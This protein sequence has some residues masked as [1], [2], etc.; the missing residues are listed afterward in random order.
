MYKIKQSL[1]WNAFIHPVLQ[2]GALFVGYRSPNRMTDKA[3]LKVLIAGG[4]GY[5]NVG[6][7]AQ[8]AA[9]L[10]LW[11]KFAPECRV[12][13]LTPDPVYTQ[14]THDK[15][16]VEFAT[17]VSLF[18][19]HGS[20]YFGSEKKFKRLYFLVAAVC[21]FNACLVRASLPT[22]G[23]TT[24]QARLLD[25]LNDSDVL[26]L[27]GGGYLTGMTLTRLWDNMLLIR[28]AHALGVPTILSGQTIGV[29]K[30][31]IS[32][33]LA[34]W[35]LK[36]AELIY[37]RD[38]VDSPAALAELGIS[39]ERFKCTFDDALFIGAAPAAAIDE[40]L[41][42][43]GIEPEK[44]YVAVNVH[45]WGL[46]SSDSRVIM[47]GMA[48]ILDRVQTSLGLQVVFVPMVQS[49][50]TAINEVMAAMRTPGIMPKHTYR[51]DLAVGI[52]QKAAL[53]LTMKHHPIIFAMAGSVPTVSMSFDDY[54][55][56]KNFGAMKIFNQERYLL[57]SSPE[58]LAEEL[59]N[60]AESAFIQREETSRQ[61][62]KVVK[63]LMCM[64]GEVIGKFMLKVNRL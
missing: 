56:H 30:D 26:F 61:I 6:D 13:V 53:C 8:L 60:L 15:V 47:A 3:R 10:Q 28:L 7:E 4:Y 5:G 63:S 58:A 54:Y 38:P 42:D 35:G 33:I 62:S 12:T 29:F 11:A 59:Y 16:R 34:G 41:R 27:S 24:A 25:E 31:S 55:H 36:K 48:N 1:L 9:N 46:S 32:R 21:L 18:G 51:P 44:P 37:L 39:G 49:D 64:S 23:L 17:R 40:I 14:K 22:F 52:I 19:S 57:K 45:Y 43:A 20:Q 2:R 50:E